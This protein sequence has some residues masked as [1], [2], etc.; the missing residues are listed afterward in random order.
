[1]SEER[2]YRPAIP[3]A[4]K[5]QVVLNQGALCGCGCG[6]PLDLVS[7]TDFDHDPALIFRPYDPATRIY[8]PDANDPESLKAKLR[9]CHKRKTFG[10]GGEKRITTRGSDIGELYKG[11][12]VTKDHELF[13]RRMLAKTTGETDPDVGKLPERKARIPSRPFPNGKANSLKGPKP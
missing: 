3:W 9:D 13:R 8:T 4:V 10:P 2:R 11:R 1:M 6:A 7:N 5:L 12:R